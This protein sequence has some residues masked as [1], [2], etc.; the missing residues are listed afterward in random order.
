MKD[1]AAESTEGEKFNC[2]DVVCNPD[3]VNVASEYVVAESGAVATDLL[4]IRNTLEP[5]WNVVDGTLKIPTK[6]PFSSVDNV[7]VLPA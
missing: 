5:V 3:A 4:S 1:P 7:A 2:C 6:L